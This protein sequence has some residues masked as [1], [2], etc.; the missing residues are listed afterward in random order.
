M[1]THKLKLFECKLV[2]LIFNLPDVR[3]LQLGY[4]LFGGGL[5]FGGLPQMGL[6]SWRDMTRF[7]ESVSLDDMWLRQNC[8]VD[9]VATC[10]GTCSVELCGPLEEAWQC[11]LQDHDKVLQLLR[12]SNQQV[13]IHQ[14]VLGLFQ[15]PSA[16]RIPAQKTAHSW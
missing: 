8:D 9:S 3:L 16:A 14:V 5:L 10:V 13:L 2:K 11:C 15:G 4:R 6:L 7:N 12:D 1:G